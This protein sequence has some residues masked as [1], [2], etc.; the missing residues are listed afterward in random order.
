MIVWIVVAIYLAIGSIVA[1]VMRVNGYPYGL[2]VG[3]LWGPLLILGLIDDWRH[4]RL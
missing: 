2:V 3:L 1:V 4:G